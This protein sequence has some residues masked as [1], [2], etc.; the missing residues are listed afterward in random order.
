[1]PL[2][3]RRKAREA[4]LRSLYQVEVGKI[5]A[6]DAARDLEESSQLE[7]DLLEFARDVFSGVLAKRAELE[8][9]IVPKLKDWEL[10]R[11]AVLD[12]LLLL[13]A[14]YELLHRDDVPPAVTL[15]EAISLAKKYSTAES[16]AFVNGVLAA[17]LADLPNAGKPAPADLE[18]PSLPDEEAEVSTIEEDSPEYGELVRS[19]QLKPQE[20]AQD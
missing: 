3:N 10:S 11:L 18:P 1:M 2:K 4:A 15:D 19:G 17:V 13:I 12:R 16:G 9:S 14:T 7:G 5:G 8:S 20:G 6:E